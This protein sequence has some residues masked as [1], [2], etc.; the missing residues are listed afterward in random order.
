M[1][2]WNHSGYALTSSVGASRSGSLGPLRSYITKAISLIAAVLLPSPAIAQA[3]PP[4]NLLD[5]ALGS[6][7]TSPQVTKV[8]VERVDPWIARVISPSPSAFANAQA[9]GDAQATFT[10][11]PGIES[12]ISTLRNAKIAKGR[13]LRRGIRCAGVAGIVGGLSLQRRFTYSFNISNAQRTL[14]FDRRT[15]V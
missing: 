1:R 14:R 5:A 15:Y 8:V 12:I 10:D 6:V 2:R 4:T 7:L 13:L 3:A 11:L 9:H